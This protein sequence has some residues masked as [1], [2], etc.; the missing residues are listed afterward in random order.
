MMKIVKIIYSII[1]WIL[2]I[3][4]MLIYAFWV[5]F[6]E[7]AIKVATGTIHHLITKIYKEEYDKYMN[8]EGCVDED[9]DNVE[10]ETEF[11][12]RVREKMEADHEI[13]V[14]S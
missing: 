1:I 10:A 14:R 5:A 6:F 13:S 4:I 7:P 12:R 3:P 8:D 11:Q 2:A 9:D